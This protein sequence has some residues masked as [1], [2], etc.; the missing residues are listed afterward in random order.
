LA[1]CG[2]A[3]SSYSEETTEE[4]VSEAPAVGDGE[5]DTLAAHEDVDLETTSDESSDMTF[6]DVG[7]VGLCTEDC[8]GH[9]AG[10]EW[11]KDNDITDASDCGGKSQSF[12]EGCEAYAE[13]LED[14]SDEE[15][16]Y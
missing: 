15:A 7:D 8:S 13:T 14:Q 16:E 6:E 9:D 12:I 3:P 2:N 10:F 5:S 4:G 11:A 1:G